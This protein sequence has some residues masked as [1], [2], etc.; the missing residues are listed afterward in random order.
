MAGAR[1]PVHPARRPDRGPGAG[2]RSSAP[3]RHPRTPTSSRSPPPRVSARRS[4][5]RSSSGSTVPTRW[6]RAIVDKWRAAGVTMEDE[7]DESTPR[8]LEGMSIVVTGSLVDFS[9]DQ[10]KEAILGPRRQ[11]RLVGVEEDRLR[12]RRRL[13][14]V[15][16]RQGGAAEGA[17]ARRGRLPGAAGRRPRRGARASR[18]SARGK[19][20]V[21]VFASPG[22]RKRASPRP[23][24]PVVD[25]VARAPGEQIRRLSTGYG[26]TVV[27]GRAARRD[28]LPRACCCTAGGATAASWFAT[29][30][31]V[32]AP[33]PCRVHAP[34]R[35]GQSPG[36]SASAGP[37]V[38]SR[39]R[40]RLDVVARHRAGPAR[41]RARGPASAIPTAVGW[42]RASP[43]TAPERVSHLALLDPTACF[44]G[45]RL[46]YNVRC[47]AAGPCSPTRAADAGVPRAGR[48][49]AATHAGAAAVAAS[50][51]GTEDFPPTSGVVLPTQAQ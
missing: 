30:R 5:R 49:A 44:R 46:G 23:T 32:A 17:G 22:R 40:G 45:G 37:A 51:S 15:Q 24:T 8:T 19:V 27:H 14:R 26:T 31:R 12:R 10:A 43:S 38:A 21:P 33:R 28:G 2:R 34:D 1:R 47:G 9:R 18:R 11:G 41:P 42:R 4:P 39:E 48:P 16:A 50:A 3:C 25:H 36:A 29:V 7:R 20:D 35:P 13:A 6:H